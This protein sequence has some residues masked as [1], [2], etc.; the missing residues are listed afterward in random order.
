MRV[1]EECVGDD[2]VDAGRDLGQSLQGISD[3]GLDQVVATGLCCQTAGLM[4]DVMQP[5]ADPSQGAV[6]LGASFDLD[7]RCSH[8]LSSLVQQV[9]LT[10]NDV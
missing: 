1:G 9:T 7:A 6:D 5:V 2:P 4:S 3:L 8:P 10:Q